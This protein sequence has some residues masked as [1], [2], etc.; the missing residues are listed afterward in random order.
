MK[1][2]NNKANIIGNHVELSSNG[3]IKGGIGA[4]GIA[5]A[6]EYESLFKE[7]SVEIDSIDQITGPE[8]PK[9]LRWFAGFMD[10]YDVDD[11]AYPSTFEGNS[12]KL[13]E[14]D[15]IVPV[16]TENT[17]LNPEITSE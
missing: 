5:G 11:H 14:A 2:Y 10:Y 6:C 13:G 1:K 4:G 15:A 16:G 7:N 9:R 8:K 12:Y 3:I 17:V